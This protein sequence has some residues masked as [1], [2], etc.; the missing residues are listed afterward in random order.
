MKLG[1]ALSILIVLW[2]APVLSESKQEQYE[3]YQKRMNERKR[4]PKGTLPFRWLFPAQHS[5]A[6]DN[7]NRRVA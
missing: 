7:L 1:L 2:V 4:L 6:S 5:K 3:K